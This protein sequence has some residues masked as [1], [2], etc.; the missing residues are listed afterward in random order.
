[1]KQLYKHEIRLN[2]QDINIECLNDIKCKEVLNKQEK[3]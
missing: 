2:I 3:N 1:M